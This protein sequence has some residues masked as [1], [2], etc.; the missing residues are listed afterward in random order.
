MI[1]FKVQVVIGAVVDLSVQEWINVSGVFCS[2]R[3]WGS[4]ESGA[5]GGR[6]WV[7]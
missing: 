4:G 5:C 1:G 7:G 3:V 6:V 2:G